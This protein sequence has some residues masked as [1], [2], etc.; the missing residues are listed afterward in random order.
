MIDSLPLT[1]DQIKALGAA[2]LEKQSSETTPAEGSPE[3]ITTACGRATDARSLKGWVGYKFVTSTAVGNRLVNQEIAIYRD[4]GTATDIFSRIQS[5][6]LECNNAQPHDQFV[7]EPTKLAWSSGLLE[8]D[9]QFHGIMTAHQIQV[10]QN[11]IVETSAS[12]I[13]DGAVVIGKI[14]DQIVAKVNSVD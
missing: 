9:K 8:R 7:N 10:V 6:A 1:L 4:K 12:R 5:D 14:T 2:Y 3:N 11:V 13:D